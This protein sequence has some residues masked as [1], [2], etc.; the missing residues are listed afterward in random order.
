MKGFFLLKKTNLRVQ[1]A[2]MTENINGWEKKNMTIVNIALLGYGTV[3][4]GVYHTIQKH[5][6][7]FKALL[8]KEVKIVAVLVKNIEKHQSPDQDV[9]LTNQFDDILRLPKLDLVIDA[10]VGRE[11]SYTYLQT[12]IKEGC[13]VI[14]AN[15]EMFAYHGE[16]LKSLADKYHVSVGFEATVAGGIPVIQTLNTLLNVNGITKVVG[17]LNGTSNFILTKMREENISFTE[18]LSIAQELGYAEQDPKN[19][20]EGIDAFFKAMILS[21]VIFGEQPKW[22]DVVRKGISG[23]TS[24]NINLFSELGLR[25]KHVAALE[26]T[27]DGIQCSVE[28]VLVSQ[29]HSLYQVEGVQNAISIDADIVGNICI[30]GP[31]AGMYP[32]AS[33]IVEDIIQ[34]A[35][36]SVSNTVTDCE[37]KNEAKA[38]PIWLI[39]GIRDLNLP[40]SLEK[41]GYLDSNHL[42]V[43]ASAEEI[44]LFTESVTEIQCYEVY[45][46]IS[47]LNIIR[48][49]DHLKIF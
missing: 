19:D 21:Q 47:H 41:M 25:F 15:K 32:T 37:F 4:Q 10:I 8:G 20:I 3:G 7:R 14:T 23:I 34:I 46:D 29:N 49:V 5:Q 11:P 43:S 28:P 48:H 36:R 12:A 38:P 45:G 27:E 18:A 22:K 40:T 42:L 39:S 17:I 31:G 30:Q 24:E 9:L 2:K 1:R 35:H 33:A 13:H 16:Q 6:S 26:K 44:T